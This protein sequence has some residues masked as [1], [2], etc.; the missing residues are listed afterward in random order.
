MDEESKGSSQDFE[1]QSEDENFGGQ[2]K[3][4]VISLAEKDP[5]PKAKAKKTKKGKKN[6]R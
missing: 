3:K 1:E 4:E 2:K 6:N 5:Q